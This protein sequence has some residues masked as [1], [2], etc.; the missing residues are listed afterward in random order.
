[1]DCACCHTSERVQSAHVIPVDEARKAFEATIENL[2]NTMPGE[3]PVVTFRVTN[4]LTGNDYDVTTDPV[5]TSS[6]GSLNVKT[7]WDTDD[8]NNTGNEE[9]N[10]SS[11]SANA[12]TGSTSNGNGSF[13]I[14]M[15]VAI[16]DGSAAPFIPAEGS[17]DATIEGHPVVDFD[18]DGTLSD[19]VPVGDVAEFFSI[20][21]ANGIVDPRRKSV[22][23]DN[24]NACH[25][26]LVLHGSNRADNID[27]CV[28]CHNP[29]NTDRRR[30]DGADEPPED[31]KQEESVDFKVMVHAI[32]AAGIRQEPITVYGFGS[33]AHVYDE[34]HVRYPGDLSNCTA[35]HTED[36]YT[37]PLEDGVL[38]TSVDTG[39]DRQSPLD[40]TVTT[41]AT[42]VCASCHDDNVAAAHM[43]S[44]GG[45]FSTTQ[46]AIDDGDVVEQCS[47]CHSEGSSAAVSVVHGID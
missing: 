42:A 19:R 1:M 43:E 28:T 33:S 17:G 35:C 20:N 14:T 5:F 4:P 40:D 6:G 16:P 38:A 46:K 36:G 29:R 37:L 26:A 39:D 15:P 41:P 45:N 21:E 12:I 8:Y 3:F 2:E 25:S 9:D 47:I 27:S 11:V 10:A 44:N 18:G 32:H 31:G 7:A 24:C 30:R 22:E 23:I 13:T 34:E